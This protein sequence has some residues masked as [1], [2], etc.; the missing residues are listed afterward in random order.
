LLLVNLL[1]LGRAAAGRR[2]RAYSEDLWGFAF[3]CLIVL[4]LVGATMAFL[5]WR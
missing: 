2:W 4:G 3:G 5:A 1:H